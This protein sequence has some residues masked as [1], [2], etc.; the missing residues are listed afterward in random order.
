MRKA[1]PRDQS[2]AGAAADGQAERALRPWPRFVTAR[3]AADYCDTSPWTIRRHVR[4]CG[5]RGRV[6]VFAIEDVER[7]ARGQAL[8]HPQ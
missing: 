6:Y 3:V 4:P 8:G 7:W 2:P 5:R 1:I